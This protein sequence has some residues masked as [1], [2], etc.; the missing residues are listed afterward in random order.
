MSK[1]SDNHLSANFFYRKYKIK[2]LCLQRGMYQSGDFILK[3]VQQNAP[4]IK[5]FFLKRI[6]LL[7]FTAPIIVK[8]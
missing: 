8:A 4:D 1:S 5:K 2:E 3:F 7:S 6:S